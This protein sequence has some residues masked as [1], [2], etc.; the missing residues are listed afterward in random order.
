[1]P[2]DTTS[3]VFSL[4]NGLSFFDSDS[5][6]GYFSICLCT[7]TTHTSHSRMPHTLTLTHCVPTMKGS[8]FGAVLDM[9]TDRST[10]T[11]LLCFLAARFPRWLLLFQ[12]LI[13]LD[14]SSHY[15]HMFR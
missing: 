4:T 5:D 1:M 6:S 13:A 11:C 15:M 8:K 3:S 14:F 12:A 9:V 10:T 2:L 7:R